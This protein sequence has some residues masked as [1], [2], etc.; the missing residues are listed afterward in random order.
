MLAEITEARQIPG[1]GRRRWFRD[2]DLDLIVWY[3]ES[4]SISGFQLCYDKLNNERALTWRSG[5]SYSHDAIDPGEETGHSKM[6]PILVADGEFDKTRVKELFF[7]KSAHI[8]PD[9]TSVVLDGIDRYP[10]G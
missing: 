4:G 10:H 1:E 8:D 2:D 7:D 6:T 9:I 5:G 3:D